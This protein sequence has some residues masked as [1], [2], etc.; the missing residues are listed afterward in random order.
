VAHAIELSGESTLVNSALVRRHLPSLRWLH[1]LAPMRHLL[2]VP[3]QSR[4]VASLRLL[5]AIEKRNIQA[6]RPPRRC[7]CLLSACSQDLRLPDRIYSLVPSV[8]SRSH[9]T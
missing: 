6:R 8:P 4:L 1:P 9:S 5:G 7:A 2:A 3:F